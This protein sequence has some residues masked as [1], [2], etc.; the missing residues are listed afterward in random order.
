MEV[1]SY[2]PIKQDPFAISEGPFDAVVA[3][4]CLQYQLNPKEFINTILG[5]SPPSGPAVIVVLQS[6]PYSEAINIVNNA[7][8]DQKGFPKHQGVLLQ[9][10][11]AVLKTVG[12]TETAFIPVE[13]YVRLTDVEGEDRVQQVAEI[14]CN[15]FG[16]DVESRELSKERLF[17]PLRRQFVDRPGEL[18][19]QGLIL[20]AKR[21]Q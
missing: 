12:F 10:A 7:L 11:E 14:L 18:G 20:L 1:L 19:Y 2:K 15:L 21:T 16:L 4:H 5:R 13:S 9:F 3:L 8:A 17:A 6:S